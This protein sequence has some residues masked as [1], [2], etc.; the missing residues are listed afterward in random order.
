MS[1]PRERGEWRDV[2]TGRVSRSLGAEAYEAALREAGFDAVEGRED[3]GG[4][5]HY[6]ARRRPWSRPANDRSL[7]SC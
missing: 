5:H 4:N 7:S 3:E 2:L 6:E 1:A